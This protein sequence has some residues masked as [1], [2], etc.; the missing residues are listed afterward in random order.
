MNKNEGVL[1]T[2]T[3][4]FCFGIF[5]NLII[6]LLFFGG[7]FFFVE[8]KKAMAADLSFGPTTGTF[9]VGSTFDVSVLEVSSDT[10]EVKST[11]GDTHLGGDRAV[12]RPAGRRRGSAQ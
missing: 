9:V 2:K 1:S 6:F 12:D 7:L 3:K 10:V 4:T 5:R 11:G 8:T